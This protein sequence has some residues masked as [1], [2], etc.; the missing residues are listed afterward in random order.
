MQPFTMQGS[1][2]YAAANWQISK[3]FSNM[4]ENAD[5]DRP[6]RRAAPIA[7]LLTTEPERPEKPHQHSGP[8]PVGGWASRVENMRQSEVTSRDLTGARKEGS[9]ERWG[10]YALRGFCYTPPPG[11]QLPEA[12]GGLD[13]LLG[14]FC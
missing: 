12:A 10:L 5:L 9:N 2:V 13:T 6:V 14:E 1:N 11:F 8:E 4:P 7:A 3:G